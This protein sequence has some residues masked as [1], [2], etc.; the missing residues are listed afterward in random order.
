MIFKAIQ[1][2]K[3]YLIITIY[4]VRFQYCIFQLYHD[5]Y[6]PEYFVNC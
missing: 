2:I 3:I 1:D 4:Q 5:N 6:V